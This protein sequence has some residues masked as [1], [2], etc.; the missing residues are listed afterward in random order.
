M[1]MGEEKLSSPSMNQSTVAECG[2]EFTLPDYYPEIKRVVSTLCRVLPES[3]YDS[4]DSVEQGGVV[5]FTVLYLGDD[6][7]ITA[8]PLTCDFT[9]VVQMPKSADRTDSVVFAE[10]TAENI[11]CRCAGPRRLNLRARLRT[12]VM[13]D[14]LTDVCA[15]VTDTAGEPATAEEKLSVQMLESEV[16]SMRRCFGRVTGNVSGE[17]RERAGTKPIMCDG[18]IMINEVT[19]TDGTVTV[20]GDALMW[21]ICFGADGLYYKAVARAPFEEKMTPDGIVSGGTARAWGRCAAVSVKD[22]DDGTL[23]WDMEYDLECEAAQNVAVKVAEDM[24]STLRCGEVQM[25]ECESQSVLKCHSGR[26]SLSGSGSRSGTATAGDY[27]MGSYGKVTCDRLERSGG[28]LTLTGSA[29]VK[30]LI[31]GGGEATE[32]TVRLP[33]KYECDCPVDGEGELFWRCDAS[34]TDASARLD[35]NSISVTAEL[36]VSLFA[37]LRCPVKYVS[38]LKLDRSAA[39]PS[40]GGV[41]RIYYPSQGE[42]AWDITK[43]YRI[44]KNAVTEVTEGGVLIE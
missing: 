38:E 10:T 39:E 21:C 22:S 24:Y 15:D 43:K 25:S 26:I 20:K 9:A 4:G 7:S 31:C 13:S 12:S 42:S 33:V 14:R 29:E 44:P 41:L 23:L 30:V 28:R 18:E 1:R 35:G 5:A 32:E 3:W 19:L 40:E 27:I 8:A 16:R 11:S 37:G 2:D 34:V 6:G 17:M 36:S